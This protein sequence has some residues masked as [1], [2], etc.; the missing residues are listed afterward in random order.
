LVIAG[1]PRQE[2]WIIGHS[3]RFAAYP[4]TDPITSQELAASLLHALSVDPAMEVR[5][6][7]TR[8]VP[9]STGAVK[10]VLFG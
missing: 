7:F 6:N 10:P 1:G 9:L 8:S 3:D 4:A 2:G 5:D